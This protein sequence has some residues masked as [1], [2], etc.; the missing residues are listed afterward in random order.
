[1][2]SIMAFLSRLLEFF[3]NIKFL[4]ISKTRYALFAMVCG[5]LLSTSA[6]Q[7]QSNIIRNG[8]FEEGCATCSGDTILPFGTTL[9]THW[10]I[11]RP[12]R[13]VRSGKWDASNG[14]VSIDLNGEGPGL[15]F[16]TF[17]TVVGTRYV[18]QFDMAGNP[19]ST[20]ASPIKELR[21]SAASD[22]ADFAFD[23]TGHNHSDMGYEEQSFIFTANHTETNLGFKSLTLGLEGGPVIDNVRVEPAGPGSRA[24]LILRIPETSINEGLQALLDTKALDYKKVEQKEKFG[25]GV[26]TEFSWNTYEA[27]INLKDNNIVSLKV[28]SNIRLGIDLGIFIE[29]CTAEVEITLKGKVGLR[30]IGDAY[31]LIFN[32][33][34]EVERDVKSAECSVDIFDLLANYFENTAEDR[35]STFSRESLNSYTQILPNI[36]EHAF[37]SS[38]PQLRVT[39]D[40][41]LIILQ[42]KLTLPNLELISLIPTGNSANLQFYATVRNS[43][44]IIDQEG[45]PRAQF[46]F[47]IRLFD[48]NPDANGDLQIDSPLPHGVVEIADPYFIETLTAGQSAVASFSTFLPSASFH[49]IYAIADGTNEVYELDETDNFQVKGISLLDADGD[50]LTD[51]DEGCV[52]GDCSTYDPYDPVNNPTGKDT[53]INKPDTDGDNL[54]DGEEINVYDTV[55][56]KPDT[57][58]DGVNDKDDILPL[59]PSRWTHDITPI[60][61][62]L[63][64]SHV[65]STTVIGRDQVD[66][67]ITL[68]YDPT[69][70]T[71]GCTPE[72][73]FVGK[74]S[75]E[76]TLK[77]KSSTPLS[78]LMVEVTN[79]ENIESGKRENRLILPDG[80]MGGVGA[81]F[82]IP[83]KDEYLDGVLR[84]GESV[85]VHFDLCLGSWDPFL[86]Y[87][88]VLGIVE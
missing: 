37:V 64:L 76:A 30:R 63:L 45:N 12:V 10:D 83:R 46:R 74:F 7:A 56:V 25:F 82:P 31:E 5:L 36:P 52:D 14:V 48:G 9:L 17:P 61:M 81:M 1:M 88:N 29:K 55:P 15:I 24:G 53:D 4:N 34:R 75:F 42:Q 11:S 40:E 38:T 47:N 20:E 70:K 26:D 54:N 57:D 77:N 49:S 6:V 41:V 59:D 62:P 79:L 19:F 21:V 72:N 84:K 2:R 66:F 18:V 78:G 69:Y 67:D 73:D 43:A 13:F 86:F 33:E 71:C 8:G 50:G 58:D 16:Q 32:G 27:N 39:D 60:I 80:N 87:V 51:Y 22:F 28:K 68:I 23:I 3:H 65:S 35:I 44:Q 85:T